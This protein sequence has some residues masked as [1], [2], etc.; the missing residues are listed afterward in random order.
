MRKG[1]AF[2]EDVYQRCGQRMRDPLDIGEFSFDEIKAAADEAKRWN[3]YLAVHT[4]NDKGTRLALEAG[5]MAIEH[6]NLMTEETMKLARKKGLFSA[7][8][9]GFSLANPQPTGT[10]LRK[11]NK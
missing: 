1:A 3:T 8:R 7:L 6:G 10:R 5:A 2:P 9:Q 4:Y 11:P